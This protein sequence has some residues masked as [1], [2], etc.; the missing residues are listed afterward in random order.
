MVRAHGWAILG[1]MEILTDRL[2]HRLAF[3]ALIAMMGEN[4]SKNEE[5]K[6]FSWHVTVSAPADT[7]LRRCGLGGEWSESG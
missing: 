3:D 2:T 1:P 6:L 5:I 7:A 4:N